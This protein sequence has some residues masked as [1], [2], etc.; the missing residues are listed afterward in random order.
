LI[1]Q[2]AGIALFDTSK[3]DRVTDE[4]NFKFDSPMFTAETVT[5]GLKKLLSNPSYRD[6][7][8]V[9]KIAAVAAGGAKKAEKTIRDYY[10]NALTLKPGQ[11]CVENLV[12]KD[13]F[14]KSRSTGV[15]K[16][17]CSCFIL[18]ALFVFILVCGFP[19]LMNTGRFATHYKFG[20]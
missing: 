18:T 9:M 14:E 11:A 13:Y 4:A 8:M 20:K 2:G 7:T 3:A 5:T 16:A 19:G 1:S 10:I 12:D 15:C 6:A 17:C